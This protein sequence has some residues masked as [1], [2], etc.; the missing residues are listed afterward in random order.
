M[1]ASLTHRGPDDEGYLEDG[2]CGFGFRR[3]SVI[4]LRTGH[5]PILSAD[6][7][8]AVILNG[9]IYNHA[10]LRA[11]FVASGRPFHTASDAE[12]ILAAYE[13][14]GLACPEVLRGMFA[15]AIWDRRER[16]LL[17]TRDRLGV[18]PLYYLDDGRRLIFGS[19]IKA[20]LAAGG[21]P[22]EIETQAVADYLGR[23][24]L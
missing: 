24:A 22:R 14:R 2:A 10:D 16:R 4:D 18:K 23:H 12:A 13:R 5:Q 15:F 17:L 3:L 20:V 8:R 9:E 19:E 6:G 1:A 7:T 21:V 11:S